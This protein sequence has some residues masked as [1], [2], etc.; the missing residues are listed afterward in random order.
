VPLLGVGCTL[1]VHAQDG[2]IVGVTSP[3]TTAWAHGAPVYQGRFGW[4]FV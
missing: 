4:Q 1:S 2:K 3:L